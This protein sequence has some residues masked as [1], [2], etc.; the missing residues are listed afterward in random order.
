VGHAAIVNLIGSTPPPEVVLRVPR[1][2]LHLYGKSAEAGRK[3][4][5]VTVVERDEAALRARLDELRAVP[6]MAEAWQM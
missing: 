4:G 6:G 2:H 1:A 3:L 5:H